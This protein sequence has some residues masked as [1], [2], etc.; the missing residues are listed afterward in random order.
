MQRSKDY[1]LRS[2]TYKL[3]IPPIPW[4]RAG[5]K[6]KRFFDKQV[7]D[8]LRVGLDLVAQHQDELKFTGP[9]HVDLRFI[10]VVP[11]FIRKR[12]KSEWH[13]TIPDIDNLEKFYFDTITKCE[14]IWTDDRIV[15]SVNKVKVW[16]K[17]AG[18]EITIKELE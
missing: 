12:P 1:K 9:L 6:G 4:Q 14:S 13:T 5:T 18:V 17:Q 16:G 10:F 7:N 3:D 8:K 15:C 2:I 11:A